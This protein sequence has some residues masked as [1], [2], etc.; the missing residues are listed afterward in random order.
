MDGNLVS[1]RQLTKNG[2]HV[3][4]GENGVKIVDAKSR[5]I[6]AK[7]YLDSDDLY[8]LQGC[9]T[10]D[11]CACIGRVVEEDVGGEATMVARAQKSI[12]MLNLWH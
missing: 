4:F 1:I 5:R 11:E 9:A 12:G 10:S 6:I 2:F 7:V 3:N 8:K